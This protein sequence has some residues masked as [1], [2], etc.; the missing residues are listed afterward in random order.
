[1]KGAILEEKEQF[2]EILGSNFWFKFSV[3]ILSSNFVAQI[4]WLK[5]AGSNFSA[6]PFFGSSNAESFRMQ[7]HIVIFPGEG[8]S[9][10]LER[11]R[12]AAA[13]WSAQR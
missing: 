1:M 11:L 10:N 4:F 7:V 9:C 6:Q 12:G 5:S 3:Q 2:L 8:G 13:D